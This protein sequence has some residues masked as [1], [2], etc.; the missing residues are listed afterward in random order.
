MS[1]WYTKYDDLIPDQNS[2]VAN[3]CHG[4]GGIE[5]PDFRLA[6]DS[7]RQAMLGRQEIR[8]SVP[9]REKLQC[10]ADQLA[11]ALGGSTLAGRTTKL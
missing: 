4:Y 7:V 9:D 3:V 5:L 11:S 1:W 6:G 8:S 2:A 10:I